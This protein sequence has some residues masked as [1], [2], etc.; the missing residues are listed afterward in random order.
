MVSITA[1]TFAENCI[2][3]IKQKKKDNTII[4]W[5]RIK[6]LNEKLDIKNSFDLVDK[7]IK[8]KFQDSPIKEQIEKI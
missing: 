6:D 5:I 2:Y 4:L 3:T 8:G 1:D 7:E